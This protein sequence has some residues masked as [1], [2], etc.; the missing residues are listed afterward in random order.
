MLAD[1]AS[2]TRSLYPRSEKNANVWYNVWLFI[3]PTESPHDEPA[4]QAAEKAGGG[5]SQNQKLLNI[6]AYPK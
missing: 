3:G 5:K 1:G 6:R 2:K 4:D